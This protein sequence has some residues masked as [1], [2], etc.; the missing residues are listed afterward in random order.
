MAG[1][2]LRVTRAHAEEE[3]VWGLG[4][5]GHLNPPESCKQVTPQVF[6][7]LGSQAV[8]ERTLFPPSS[9]GEKKRP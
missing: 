8:D 5:K 7:T 2:G 6:P 4:G 3:E 9:A 1:S